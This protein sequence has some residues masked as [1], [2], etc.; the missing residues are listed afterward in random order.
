M[1]IL[2]LGGMR[3]QETWSPTPDMT[4]DKINQS[5][6]ANF[7]AILQRAMSF[8]INH[9]ETARAYGTSEVQYGGA[10]YRLDHYA[11]FLFV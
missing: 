9:I 5:V 1:P 8:G 6:Q 3:M 7:D 4:L 10:P 11:L 2:T